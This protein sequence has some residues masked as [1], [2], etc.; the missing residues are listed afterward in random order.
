MREI[1]ETVI[2]K[3]KKLQF[4]DDQHGAKTVLVVFKTLSEGKDL[5]QV[6]EICRKRAQ[7]FRAEN[8]DLFLNAADAIEL[9]IERQ[10]DLLKRPLINQ[11]LKSEAQKFEQHLYPNLHKTPS[12]S[13]LKG[14]SSKG[15]NT[16]KKP[17][18]AQS[19]QEQPND[20]AEGKVEKK[21]KLLWV[22]E[23]DKSRSLADTKKI[24]REGKGAKIPHLQKVQEEQ[25]NPGKKND[26]L[27]PS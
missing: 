3:I 7:G 19:E 18:H 6:V 2:D 27:T 14:D 20:D 1:G 5:S 21:R 4:C 15:G 25:S 22:D 9:I 11:E 24:R 10:K 17:C 23:V 16:A 26:S 12:K 8:K 13:V